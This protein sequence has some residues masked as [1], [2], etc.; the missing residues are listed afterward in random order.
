MTVRQ[1]IDAG[2]KAARD[3]KPC[4]YPGASERE[5]AAWEQG[6]RSVPEKERGAYRWQEPTPG[7]GVIGAFERQAW[8]TFYREIARLMHD[9]Y[10]RQQNWQVEIDGTVYK[11]RADS[12]AKKGSP[13][14][15]EAQDE[16]ART[17]M[18]CT[19]CG[20]AVTADKI[21]CHGRHEAFCPDCE[22]KHQRYKGTTT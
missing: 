19:R 2:E 7:R 18:Q 12:Y 8:D 22:E 11:F 21:K 1:M 14:W 3:G 9:K 15:N 10:I 5:R 6:W 13:R 16:A 20:A 4:E 17:Q